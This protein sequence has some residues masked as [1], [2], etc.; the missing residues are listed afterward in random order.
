[1]LWKKVANSLVTLGTVVWLH[2]LIDIDSAGWSYQLRAF[3]CCCCNSYTPCSNTKL[4]VW[5]L[6]ITYENVDQFSHFFYQQ[7]PKET[8]CIFDRNF[9]SHLLRCYTTLWNLTLLFWVLH[10]PAGRGPGT[11]S[12]GSRRSAE[13]NDARIQRHCFSYRNTVYTVGLWSWHSHVMLM[14]NSWTSDNDSAKNAFT[15]SSSRCERVPYL[16]T[17]L[18]A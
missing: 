10:F 9:P 15:D 16:L 1:M 14:T 11:S 13:A 5:F 7:I 8:V 17:Y 6:V 18:L 2:Q 12:T 4:F 3:C